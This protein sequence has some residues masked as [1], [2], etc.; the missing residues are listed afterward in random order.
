MFRSART[1]LTLL[2]F[3]IMLLLYVITAGTIYVLMAR[4]TVGNEDSLLQSSATPLA[5]QVQAALNHG[6]FP[7]E[8]VNLRK[9]DMLFPRLSTIVLRDAVG[10]ILADTQPTIAK[11][12]PSPRTPTAQAQTIFLKQANIWVRVWSVHLSNKYGQT[13]GDLQL[14]LNVT[15]D[16]LSLHRLKLVVF[17][18]GVIGAILT[19]LSGFLVSDRALQPIARSWRRQQRF[20]ADASH[21]I[22][23]P[24]AVISA[25]LDLV[26]DH[27][28]Q[29]V[30]DNLEW[31]SNARTE[32]WRLSKLTD[33]LLTLARID[34]HQAMIRTE[35]VDLLKVVES[36]VETYAVLAE[37]KDITL[38]FDVDT[39]TSPGNHLT[40]S[41]TLMGDETRLRQLAVIIIDNAIKYT[42]NGGTVRVVLARRRGTLRLDVIDSGIGISQ[43]DLPRVFDRFYRS[44]GARQRSSGGTGLGLSIAKWIATM[45]R[46][47][48]SVVSQPDQ[49]THFTIVL[50]L[51]GPRTSPSAQLSEAD[52][53]AEPDAGLGLID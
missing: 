43:A 2:F 44:D 23:S 1:R 20:V 36:V 35:E 19:L 22:R 42:P 21:E 16:V 31:L 9:L 17:E 7:Q 11:E 52:M 26:L 38:T 30:L 40:G 32:L 27:T 41:F 53:S 37:A 6:Q 24:L 14:A 39:D 49:G 47:K 28:D 33:D 10:Q 50:P 5:A 3:S 4:L 29:S 8:F 15:G 51:H 45:H 48:V 25:N 18:V 12:L 13:T 34:S 46:G